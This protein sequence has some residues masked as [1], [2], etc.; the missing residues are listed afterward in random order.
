MATKS[1][2]KA[3]EEELPG[4]EVVETV[5]NAGDESLRRA[6]K[7][8]P[9]MAELRRKYLGQDVQVEP[10]EDEAQAEVAAEGDVDVVQ[11][12][13]KQTPADPADD[14]GL[15]SIIRSKKDGIIGYQ[16]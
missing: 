14:P 2:K 7:P 3:I 10:A 6:T 15:R 4:I 9:S 13:N 1:T 12:R 5:A 11:V 16:G 8:G